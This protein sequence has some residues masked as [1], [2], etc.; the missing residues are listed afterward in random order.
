MNLEK[1]LEYQRIDKQIYAMEVE[2]KNTEA[3]KNY[4]KAMGLRKACTDDLMKSLRDSEEIAIL[5]D[6][7]RQTYQK[8][9]DEMNGLD[10][11]LDSFEELK[12]ID[13]YEKKI[14]QYQKELL[15]VEHE[16]TKLTKRMDDCIK[17]SKDS[18]AK[19]AKCD[20]IIKNA[21]NEMQKIKQGMQEKVNVLMRKLNDLKLDIP[22]EIIDK[23]NAIRKNKM[24]VLVPCSDKFTACQGCGMDIPNNLSSMLA[25]NE[26]VE[27][28]N[29]GRLIYNDK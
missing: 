9:N 20:D 3:A 15:N 13:K 27:C 8:I 24:P 17:I 18:F 22:K 7:Y 6:R 5:V 11:V 10:D 25:K 29:C 23:Y 26:I 14:A 4:A 19:V 1:I 12:E 28:P 21:K 2:L 16:L